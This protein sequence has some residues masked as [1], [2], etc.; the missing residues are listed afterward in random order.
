MDTVKYD[1]V[2]PRR[3]GGFDRTGATAEEQIKWEYSALA[4]VESCVFWFPKE[5]LCP[6]TL[7]ELGKMLEKARK[8]PIIRLAIGWHPEYAR[9]FDLGVQIGLVGMKKQIIHAAPGWNGLC[10]VVKNTWG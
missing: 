3:V 9:A 7:F 2:N 5:T 1:V 6:I 8:D 10:D 4:H